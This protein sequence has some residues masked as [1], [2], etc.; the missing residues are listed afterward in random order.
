MEPS[1]GGRRLRLATGLTTT[2][3]DD[4]DGDGS[5]PVLLLHGWAGSRRSFAAL[6]PLLSRRVRAIT[7]DL[8]GHGDA[9]K[10]ATGYDL[11]TLAADVVATLDALEIPRAVLVGAS[12]GG[13][14]AQQVAVT[15]PDRMA[16][17]VLAGSPQ[18][19]RGRPAFADD[20]DGLTD[21]LDPAWV[22]TFVLGFTELDRLPSWYVDLMVDDALRVPAPIW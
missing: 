10:P 19:L 17:L 20:L 3:S 7:V 12:S 16:G 15:N 8:R 5:S 2:V 13:Y 4:G 6:L 21:P 11:G 14:V 18:D 9:D 1:A 22:R